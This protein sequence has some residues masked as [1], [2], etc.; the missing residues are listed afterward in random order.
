[1]LG[2]ESPRPLYSRSDA[3]PVDSSRKPIKQRHYIINLTTARM[4]DN[5]KG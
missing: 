2:L 3:Q 4:S 1:M 5:T